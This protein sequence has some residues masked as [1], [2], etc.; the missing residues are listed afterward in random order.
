MIQ[1]LLPTKS[2][3]FL[4]AFSIRVSTCSIAF[5][6]FLVRDVILLVLLSGA[7][8]LAQAQTI[9]YV[10]PT[11]TGNR[12]GSSWANASGD[13]QAMI[14]ASSSSQQ[15]WVAAGTYKP[16]TGTDRKI[17]FSMKN[18]VVIYGGF[19]S[20]GTPGS[21]T[22]RNPLRFTTVLSGDI[23]IADNNTDNSYHV[24]NNPSGLTNT[25][26]LDGFLITGG[27]ASVSNS[28][29]DSGGGMIN[30]GN[31]A[32]NSCSPLIR[33]CL[34]LGNKAANV[35]GALYNAGFT[36]GNSNPSLI[37]CAFQSN[38]AANRGGAIYND[39]SVGGNSNPSLTNCSFQANLAASGGAMGNLSFQGNSRPVLTNCVVWGNGGATTFDNQQG[40]FIATSYSLFENTVTGYN[41][42]MGNLIAA[43]SPFASTTAT[44]LSCD[45]WAIDSGDP[46]ITAATVGSIDLVGNA[47]FVNVRTVVSA[48]GGSP[49]IID[50]GAYEVQGYIDLVVNV[51]SVATATIGV[52]FSESFTASGGTGPYTYSLVSGSLPTGLS[53]SPTGVLSG[54]PTEYG[55]FTIAVR[56]TDDNGCTYANEVRYALTTPSSTPIRYV[57]AGGAGSGESWDEA[58]GDLQSQIAFAGAEQVWVAQGIYKPGPAGNTDRGLSFTMKDGV[59]ILGGFPPSGSPTLAERNPGRFPTVL[60]GDI[61]VVGDRSDNSAHVIYNPGYLSNSAVLD[62][63]VITDAS[64]DQRGGGMLNGTAF[65]FQTNTYQS[66]SPVL[67]NCIFQNNSAG[68]GGGLCNQNGNPILI[69]CAFLNNS[70]GIGAGLYNNGNENYRTEPTLVNCSFQG[71]TADQGGAIYNFSKGNRVSL[72]NCVV[73]GNGGENTFDITGYI[74][75]T[76]SLLDPTVKYYSNRGNTMTTPFSPFVSTTS[77]QLNGFN[78]ALNAGSNPANTTITDLAGNPRFEGQIDMGAYEL[79]TLPIRYVRMGGTGSGTSW[80]DASGDLQALISGSNQQVWVAQGTYKPGPAGSTDRSISFSMKDGVSILGGFPPTGSPTL[81]G[82]NPGRFPAV[83]SGDIGVVGDRSDN[84]GQVIHNQSY[85]SNSA[86]LDGFVITGGSGGGGMLNGMAA[87]AALAS[88]FPLNVN[89]SCSPVL[90]N[91]LFQNNSASQ[92]GGLSNQ[93]GNPILINCSFLSNSA[94]SGGGLYNNGENRTPTAA[95]LIN[96]SF[97]GNKA[98]TPGW[99]IYNLNSKRMNVNLTNCVLFDN[100][101]QATW[102]PLFGINSAYSLFE[103]TVDYY[104]DK[105]T[106]LVT[107]VSPFVSGTDARLRTGSEAIDAGDPASTNATSGATDLAGN[108]RFVG[109]RIDMGAYEFDDAALPVSLVSFTAQA[110]PDH[111]VLL[112]WKTA[113]ELNNKAYLIERSKDLRNFESIGQVSDVG[114]TSNQSNAY[115]FIDTN[116]Y[117]GT[118]YYRLRQVDLDGSSQTYP[119]RSVIIN[120][121]YGV[122]PNPVVGQQFTLNLDE[123]YSV[124]LRLYSVN[125]REISLIHSASSAASTVVRPGSLL[126]PGIYLLTVEERGALREYRLVVL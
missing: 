80:A 65:N 113:S 78:P 33:N 60:S 95:A 107:S 5:F 12:S 101:G 85:L 89:I 69:N 104:D 34:F 123:P 23:G 64:S 110:Q 47:R 51:P 56:V 83:L 28:P 18:G 20:T 39:G 105:G 15:V 79:Q 109:A 99:A 13:L 58:S 50:M 26:V 90:R 81:A 53:L 19:A 3:Y 61:G 67:R 30:N 54:T 118:S 27:N 68:F 7:G 1:P 41:T 6:H 102:F 55:H 52:P 38:N 98:D 42:G 35:G 4:F 82:R 72:T 45:S 114:G 76:Y 46:A 16:T 77:T 100:G 43:G 86:V 103:P 10:K 115:L 87:S 32:G 9:R 121:N 70:A 62:G 8:L 24:I 40:A 29:D 91:C 57:R 126:T 22:E 92:G 106:N 112:S 21:L 88:Q 96:C 119:A 116:P 94:G 11:A 25:A 63:F 73:F 71:N 36:S 117:Q 84:T 125:G 74:S 97:Q 111:T 108:T 122:Y 66:S 93:N 2:K 37:N 59:S 49:A 120:G 44:R 75:I 31:G 14:N 124:V 48:P 17:S